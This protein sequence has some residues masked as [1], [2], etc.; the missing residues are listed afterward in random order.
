M[1]NE[2]KRVPIH[3]ALN[4]PDM[5]MGCERELALSVGLITLI[6]V[7]VAMSFV[8]AII[9]LCFYFFSMTML[10]MMG[11]ADPV[12]SKVYKRHIKYQSYYPPHSTPFAINKFEGRD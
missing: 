5:L 1:S 9:G 10:R 2:L 4:R 12:M 8:A 7:V 6:L 11:K 3:R